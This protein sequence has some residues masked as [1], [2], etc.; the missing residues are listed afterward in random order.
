MYTDITL[1]RLPCGFYDVIICILV[2]QHFPPN[3][4]GLNEEV[5]LSS[6]YQALTLWAV[7]GVV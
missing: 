4:G 6:W 7:H 2:T 5:Q 3:C 1:P